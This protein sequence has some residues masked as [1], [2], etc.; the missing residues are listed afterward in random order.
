MR[1]DHRH[2]VVL[3]QHVVQ[4]LLHD[5]LRRRIQRRRGLVQERKLRHGGAQD[6]GPGDAEELPLAL[7]EVLTLLVDLRK[8]AAGLW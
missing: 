3:G 8:E 7:G 5:L 4:R 1:H 2:A 6:Q